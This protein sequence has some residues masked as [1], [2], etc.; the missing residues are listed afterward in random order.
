MPFAVP[1]A[2]F[3]VF[4][5]RKARSHAIRVF[6]ICAVFG[7]LLATGFQHRRDLTELLRAAF[8]QSQPLASRVTAGRTQAAWVLRPIDPASEFIQAPVGL[9]FYSSYSSDVCRRVLFD[10]RT[11][12]TYEAGYGHCGLQNPQQPEHLGV[13]RMLAMS[14]AFKK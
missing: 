12:V 4:P 7:A 11:G 13:E 14:K 1:F 9:M 5:S 10:N 3:R 2:A 6:A 8:S